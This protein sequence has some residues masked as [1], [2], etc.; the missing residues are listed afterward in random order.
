[1]RHSVYVDTRYC[2]L[3]RERQTLPQNILSHPEGGAGLF[4]TKVATGLFKTKVSTRIFKI[5]LPTRIFKTKLVTRIFKIKLATRIF[6]INQPR[7]I[8]NIRTLIASCVRQQT[9]R[10]HHTGGILH[11]RHERT[12]LPLRAKAKL[13]QN[14]VISF[15]PEY[16]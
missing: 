14:T 3:H 5:K 13:F 10:S 1:M 4:K 2:Q 12:H 9:I 11:H 15:S 7:V 16:S 6:K 8:T